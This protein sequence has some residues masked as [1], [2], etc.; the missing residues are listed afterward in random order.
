MK[1]LIE[2]QNSGI[3]FNEKTPEAVMR[4]ISGLYHSP[5]REERR[6]RIFYGDQETGRSWNEENDVMGFI[7]R[8][9]GEKKIPLLIHS[10]RSHGGPAILTDCIIGIILISTKMWLYKHEKF[11]TGNWRIAYNYETIESL[12]PKSASV[13]C[14]GT[15]V[16][17]FNKYPVKAEKYVQFMEGKRFSK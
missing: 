5:N 7:G 13:Y 10:T 9:T 8:S 17:N 15:N 3:W 6:I 14:D 4:I 12:L 1:N 2:Y 11:H 16:A